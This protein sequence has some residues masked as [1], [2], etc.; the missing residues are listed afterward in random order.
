MARARSWGEVRGQRALNEAR[1]ETYRQVMAAQERIAEL[2]ASQGVGEEQ[3][4]R[5]LAAA[6]PDA[7][8]EE[9]EEE[10][11]LASLARFVAALGG[12]L[13]VHAVF[14]EARVTVMRTDEPPLTGEPPPTGGPA[15]GEMATAGPPGTP[16][17]PDG[18]QIPG[19]EA[20]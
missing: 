12:H 15:T 2:L 5:A 1:V 4:E 6:H 20:S 3:I 17:P 19:S 18:D 14:P 8:S 9:L 7:P 10:V 13:E 16:S 11:Y